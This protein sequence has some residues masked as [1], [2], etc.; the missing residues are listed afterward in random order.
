[1]AKNVKLL[2]LCVTLLFGNAYGMLSRGRVPVTGLEYK[3]APKQPI[4]IQQTNTQFTRN[5]CGFS[6]SQ[7][8]AQAALSRWF[9][10][11][12]NVTPTVTNSVSDSAQGESIDSM[13]TKSE[14]AARLNSETIKNA[15]DAARKTWGDLFT[16]LK[17]AHSAASL[18]LDRVIG[19]IAYQD[20]QYLLFSDGSLLDP[21]S[22]F[23][24]N[25]S[26][27]GGKKQSRQS[28]KQSN[29]DT[30]HNDQT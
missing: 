28:G 1:M 29:S 10:S 15:M 25:N 2:F 19:F 13:P 7:N 4:G 5:N 14:I 23:G 8:A 9:T 27:S 11:V 24:Q 16:P 26:S 12:K 17:A 22:F 6:T 21:A 20:K 18:I 30:Y 3:F